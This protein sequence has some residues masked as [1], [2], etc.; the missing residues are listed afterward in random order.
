[1]NGTRSGRY[2]QPTRVQRR[3]D[4][5]MFRRKNPAATAG[6]PPKHRLMSRWL[7]DSHPNLY[8]RASRIEANVQQM[9]PNKQFLHHTPNRR[10]LAIVA[11]EVLIGFVHDFK[12]ARKKWWS[13]EPLG[14]SRK[15]NVDPSRIPFRIQT[16]LIVWPEKIP[17][18][19]RAIVSRWK[20]STVKRPC[21]ISASQ[22][23]GRVITTGIC[24]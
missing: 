16:G 13:R 17:V 20:W 22:V 19:A 6:T 11:L 8:S 4:R 18:F 10:G 1:M 3:T 12:H 14:A 21:C 24:Y 23:I 7:S 2:N 5:N 15:P 9:R